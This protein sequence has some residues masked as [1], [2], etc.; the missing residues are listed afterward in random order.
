MEFT[1]GI[2]SQTLGARRIA[3]GTVRLVQRDQADSFMQNE[4]Y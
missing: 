1:E 3:E 2:D 4:L